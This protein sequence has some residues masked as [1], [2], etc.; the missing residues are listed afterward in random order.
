MK[1]LV[2]TLTLMS[3]VVQS[4]ALSLAGIGDCSAVVLPS[5]PVTVVQLGYSVHLL[6]LDTASGMDPAGQIIVGTAK[7]A[8]VEYINGQVMPLIGKAGYTKITPTAVSSNGYIVGFAT[9]GNYIRGLFWASYTNAPIDMGALD[10]ATYPQAINS[11]GVAVGYT[12]S[13]AFIWS[14]SGGIR[15]IGPPGSVWSQA[16]DISESGYVAGL[17]DFG[18]GANA[19]RWYPPN[20]Q[21]GIAAYNNYANKV[22]E[23]GTIYGNDYSWSLPNNQQQS[24]TPTPYSLVYEISTTGRKVGYDYQ[25]LRAWTVPPGGTA[26]QTLPVPA[27]IAN[28]YADEV[29]GCGVIL[30]SVTYTNGTTQAVTWTKSTCDGGPPTAL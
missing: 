22:M 21:Y 18:A 28:S 4:V 26:E 2:T 8:A 19:T 25:T 6:P 24:I 15:S 30:G 20:D 27:G 16:F 11:Q 1:R 29:T 23:N 9:S 14:I 17:S 12:A 5:P 10:A 13:K 3:A 7:G